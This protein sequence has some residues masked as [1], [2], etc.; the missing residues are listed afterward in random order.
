MENGIVGVAEVNL[1]LEQVSREIILKALDKLWISGNKIADDARLLV[2]VKTGRLRDSIVAE[3]PIMS[4]DEIRCV[5]SA[6][7]TY[8]LFVEL[9]TWKMKARPYL[10]P[11]LYKNKD[12][13]ERQ[14][15]G[16]VG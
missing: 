9:G 12:E 11:S 16:L 13:F 15:K 8:A 14:M 6:S 1:K 4:G 3:T 7:T 2:P 5:I 10:K